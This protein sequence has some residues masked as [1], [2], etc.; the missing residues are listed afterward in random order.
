M[1]DIT[2][3]EY[4]ELENKLEYN[5][6]LETLNAKE[7]FLNKKIDVDK[8][9]YSEVKYIFKTIPKCVENESLIKNV[10]DVCYKLEEN[11]FLNASVTEL[12]PCI[13]YITDTF[14]KLIEQEAKLWQGYEDADSTLWKQAGGDKLNKWRYIL[15]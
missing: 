14:K 11:D 3:K 10:F 9:S 5:L 15:P 12:F 2:I 7:T 6:L 13:K 8:L 4:F 1:I